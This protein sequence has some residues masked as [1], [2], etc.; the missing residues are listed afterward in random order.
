M[1][2]DPLASMTAR[3]VKFW[4][5]ACAHFARAPPRSIPTHLG[6]NQLETGELSPCLILDDL[7]D[8]WVGLG[9]VGVKASVLRLA[10]KLWGWGV[11]DRQPPIGAEARSAGC[12]ISTH[13]VLWDGDGG[14]HSDRL[15]CCLCEERGAGDD[16]SQRGERGHVE[17]EKRCWRWMADFQLFEANHSDFRSWPTRNT[18]RE[19][20]G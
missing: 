13:K 11:E 14:S 15:F 19:I 2:I 18:N 4:S 12:G 20:S 9:E 10:P 16:V 7:G 3:E 17:G 5:S 1:S 6:S 8:L